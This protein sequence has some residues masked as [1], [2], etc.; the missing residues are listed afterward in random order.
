LLEKIRKGEAQYHIIEI[1]ACPGGCLN[2][3]GQPYTGGRCDEILAKRM[4]AIY[5]DD[6]NAKIRKSHQNPSIKKLY[7]EFLGKPGSELSHKLL[8]THYHGRR[9]V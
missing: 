1:M 2:G 9:N 4:E 6:K 7:E 8:H 3:G 5:R